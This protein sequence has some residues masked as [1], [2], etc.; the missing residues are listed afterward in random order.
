M[1]DI[2]T[3]YNEHVRLK[4]VSKKLDLRILKAIYGMIE[5]AL[6]WYELY[7]GV[8]K[9]MELQLN[10]YDMCVANKDINGEQWTIAYYL[11]DNK[12]SHVEQYVIDDVI[13]KVEERFLVL[14]VTK[15]NVHTFLGS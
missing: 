7:L 15:C 8:I 4:D 2:N 10:T 12:V 9:D 13:S 1:Y 3:D 5:S 6:L 14:K 11:N